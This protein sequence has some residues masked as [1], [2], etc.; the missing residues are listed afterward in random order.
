MK[1]NKTKSGGRAPDVMSTDKAGYQ[2][3][4]TISLRSRRHIVVLHLAL[5]LR[6]AKALTPSCC[7]AGFY[8]FTTN[9]LDC[10]GKAPVNDQTRRQTPL[11]PDLRPKR[12]VRNQKRPS[13]APLPTDNTISILY[14]SQKSI[15]T[16]VRDIFTIQI[17]VIPMGLPVVMLR[18]RPQPPLRWQ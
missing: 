12:S 6:N 18:L 13:I 1:I 7:S 5:C 8:L 15:L 14:H 16:L 2:A 10:T 4:V 17:L 3:L 9:R 11:V